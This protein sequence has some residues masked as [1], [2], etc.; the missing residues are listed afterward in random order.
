M[1]RNYKN[2]NNRPAWENRCSHVQVSTWRCSQVKLVMGKMRVQAPPP[3][4]HELLLDLHMTTTVGNLKC[5]QLNTFK[6]SRTETLISLGS[7]EHALKPSNALCTNHTMI[8]RA[9]GTHICPSPVFAITCSREC[10]NINDKNMTKIGCLNAYF[11]HSPLSLVLLFL[12]ISLS[13]YS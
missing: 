7:I 5:V 12:Y 6:L 9:A 2:N 13:K 10:L 1:E 4:S 3:R 8:L 11:Y